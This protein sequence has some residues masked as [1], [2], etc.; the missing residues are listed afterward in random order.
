MLLKVSAKKCLFKSLLSLV[1]VFMTQQSIAQQNFY[2][3]T[4]LGYASNDYDGL[5]QSQSLDA[6]SYKLGVGYE[7]NRSWSFEAGFQSLGEEILSMDEL[8]FENS[9]IEID[10]I[11]LNALGRAG[12]RHGELF[13]RVGIAR[14]DTSESYL[15]SA[16]LCGGQSSILAVQQDAMLCQTSKSGMA[17]VVG[18]GFDFYIHHSTLLR[19]EAEYMSGENGYSTSAT[20]LG[21]RLNF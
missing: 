16:P 14:V 18:L 11:Y 17:G 8:N 20:Y 10:N 2:G 1:F 15:A 4:S 13:Y 7:Y 9:S 5:S 19:I 3:I 21:I 6:V 12:N